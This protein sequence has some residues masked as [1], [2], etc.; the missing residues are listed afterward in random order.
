M[1]PLNSAIEAE[2]SADYRRALGY[3]RKLA[4][5]GSLLDRIGIYQAIARCFEKLG[6]LKKA[7][8]WHEKA[9]QGYVKLP[10]K[11]MG[12]QE[13][14]YY[15]MVEF[16][17][18]LQDYAPNSS[19]RRAAKSYLNSLTICLRTS[20]EG[21]SHEMLFAAHLYAKIREFKRAADFFAD[22][23]EEFKKEKEVKL[24]NETYELAAKYYV[25]SGNSRFARRKAAAI[26]DR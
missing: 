16:R 14:A 4:S 17:S 6:S 13:R 24:A 9:G 12:V 20:K 11:I 19:M 3:Y 8:Y 7:G 18:A 15:G 25:R 22:T 10:T 23:A 26:Q 2:L 21:Y 5:Q 1:G